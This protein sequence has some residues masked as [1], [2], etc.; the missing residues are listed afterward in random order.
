MVFPD[1]RSH[2]IFPTFIYTPATGHQESAHKTKSSESRPGTAFWS[3]AHEFI[4]LLRKVS[5]EA[6]PERNSPKISTACNPFWANFQ[7][8]QIRQF[9]PPFSKKPHKSAVLE[10]KKA[11]EEPLEA[12]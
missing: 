11:V 1:P 12:L 6:I 10:P 2:S 3:K 4:R 5:S 9:P 8:H 7:I